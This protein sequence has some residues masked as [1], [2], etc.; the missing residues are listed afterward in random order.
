[1]YVVEERLSLE[2]VNLNVEVEGMKN[3]LVDKEVE[4]EGLRDEND[5]F[6]VVFFLV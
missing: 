1:M 4:C 6:Y 5:C 3:C 2:I